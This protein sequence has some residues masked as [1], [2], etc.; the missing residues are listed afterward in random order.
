MIEPVTQPTQDDDFSD[1]DPGQ[2]TQG[3]ESQAGTH[4][5]QS[6]LDA[7]AMVGTGLDLDAV[8][9]R[10]VE[11]AC[12]VT[13]ARYGALGVLDPKHRRLQEFVYHGIDERTARAIGHLPQGEGILGLLILDPRPLRIAEISAHPDS[14]G[15][16]PNHPAM[17]S[18]LGV[19]VFT[20]DQVFGNLYLTEKQG[21]TEF[22]EQDERIITHFATIAGVAIA[23]AQMHQRR[24][25]V[26]VATERERIARDLH[27]SVIQ[28]IFSVGLSLQTTLSR[29]EDEKVKAAI[30]QAIEDLDGTIRQ[31]RTTI[32]TLEPPAGTEEGLRARVL[33]IC[34]EASRMLGFDPDVSFAGPVDD[35]PEEIGVEVLT[36]LREA[37]SNVARHAKARHVEVELRRNGGLRLRV[38]DDGIGLQGR[39]ASDTA[40]ASG[41][42]GSPEAETVLPKTGRGI[43]DMATRAE[44]LGGSFSLRAHP[45]GG[46]ELIW[47][48]PVATRAEDE[49]VSDS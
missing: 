46:S 19:P 25:E 36:T 14:V 16:P 1:A 20:G 15:F 24:E 21:A 8:L 18:F 39:A 31:I 27:D 26:R 13:N 6:V 23:N 40:V 17:H 42:G 28:R 49:A 37:L 38:R 11:A 44:L 5:L 32:F 9:K 12:T 43:P 35:T 22:T 4:V 33:Q 41:K 48:V 2:A 47:H 34:S 3:I 30:S 45:E 10:I 7:V 29:V